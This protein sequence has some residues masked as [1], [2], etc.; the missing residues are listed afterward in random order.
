M[1]IVY[2]YRNFEVTS[3]DIEVIN[4]FIDLNNRISR[5]QISIEI[6]K[7]FNWRQQNG[8]LRDQLCRSFLLGLHR[9]GYIKLPPP[10]ISGFSPN[11]KKYKP[12]NIE[13]NKDP[14]ECSLNSLVPITI[15]QVRLTNKELYYNALIS[16]YHY[17]GYKHP[18]GENLKYIASSKGRIIACFAF[19]SAPRHIGSR[20]KHIGWD[21]KKRMKNIQLIAYNTRFLILEWVKVRYLASHLLS[22]IAGRISSDWQKTYNHPIYYLETFVDT[23]LYK[24]TCYKAANWI[25]IGYT[26]GIGIKC[27]T[28][29]ANLSIKEVLGYPLHRDYRG[30]LNA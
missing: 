1:E 25:H 10:R 30:L 20:D 29:K 24:G 23:E 21:Q 2:K 11:H 15:E 22:K 5:R 6:C 18:V 16:E 7:I 9:E 8:V 13:I 14:I 28:G 26:K 12:D 17:L 27:K 3:R 19:C 4:N